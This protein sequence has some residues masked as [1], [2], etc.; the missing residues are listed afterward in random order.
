MKDKKLRE[1]INMKQ[2]W[3]VLW[4]FL[5]L[6]TSIL[7]LTGTSHNAYAAPELYG[8]NTGGEFFTIDTNDGMINH[9]YDI[10]C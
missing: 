9:L 7:I 10:N 5:L 3:V 2:K 1:A 4:C 6:I 8:G